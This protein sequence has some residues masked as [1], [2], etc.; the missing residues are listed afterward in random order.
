MGI[1]NRLKK[2]ISAHGSA[3]I[4]PT[5]STDC[6][7]MTEVKISVQL[8]SDQND[9]ISIPVTKF[10]GLE[11]NH[12]NIFLQTCNCRKFRFIN[13]LFQLGDIARLCEHL[14]VLA[15][16][17][18]LIQTDDNLLYELFLNIWKYRVFKGTMESGDIVYFAYGYEDEWIDVVVKKRL[19]NDPLGQHS[20]P[21]ERFGFNLEENRWSYGVNPGSAIELRQLLKV[22]SLKRKQE[23]AVLP[24]SFLRSLENGKRDSKLEEKLQERE[25][26]ELKEAERAIVANQSPTCCVCNS[27]LPLPPRSKDGTH[28]ICKTCG[29]ENVI[30]WGGFSH[31]PER[32]AI[33]EHYNGKYDKTSLGV[34]GDR[35]ALFNNEVEKLK[36]FKRSGKIT[37]VE[38]RSTRTKLKRILDADIAKLHEEKKAALSPL[39]AEEKAIRIRLNAQQNKK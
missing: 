6:S 16:E 1:I 38:Y 8:S 37:D 29:I 18:G 28:A 27:E 12:C 32:I 17:K 26:Q 19:S 13:Y 2:L 20:G 30:L 4:Q 3:S 36:E 11:T 22:V 15:Y 21:Y 5:A 10:S 14:R 39:S 23:I 25:Q 24:T 31:R 33:R 7:S 35:E 34:I 9:N